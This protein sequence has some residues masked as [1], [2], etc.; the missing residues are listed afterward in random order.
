MSSRSGT[1]LELVLFGM[2]LFCFWQGSTGQRE[3]ESGFRPESRETGVL[4]IATWN[5]GTGVDAGTE[6]LRN[7]DLMHVAESIRALDP[8]LVFLQELTGRFQ[9]RSLGEALGEG[10]TWELERAA[11]GR[12]LGVMAQHGTLRKLEDK[13]LER[14]LGVEFLQ[15]GRPKVTCVGLHASAFSSAE[16]NRS[17]GRASDFLA[18]IKGRVVL[19]GDLNLDLDIDKRHD[20]F[21]DDEYRDVETYNYL[22]TYLFDTGLGTGSTAK[23]DR[24]LDYIF[25]GHEDFLI[26]QVGPWLGQRAVA[27]DHHPLVADLRALE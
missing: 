22:A 27:M 15:P 11:S 19:V 18:R 24:R 10:W 12:P 8:D 26:S 14:A 21:T 6:G 2:A 4:R 3:L 5:L 25:V 16:R 1:S 23:P 17:I 9:L 7:E 13:L 20:L